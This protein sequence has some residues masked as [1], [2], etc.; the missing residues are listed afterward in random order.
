MSTVLETEPVAETPAPAMGH[1]ETL[2]ASVVILL[3]MTVAQRLIGFGRGILFCRWLDP[4]QLGQW[5]V[6]FGFL[7]LAASVAVLGLP[8][9]FGRYIGYFRQ[10]GQF[11]SFLWRTSAVS[12]LVSIVT[13]TIMIIQRDK[14]SWL[15]FGTED[16]ST[17][18]VYLAI[19]VAIIILHNH[20][21][22]LFIAVRRYRIV[23][24]LQFFQ[25]LGF[26]IVSL[27]LMMIWP[28]VCASVIIGYTVATVL[29]GFGSVRCMR[30]LAAEEPSTGQAMPQA[31]FWAKLM[32]FAIWMWFT[33]FVANLFDLV[34][35]YMIVHH[36]GMEA[37]EA[38]RQIGFYSSSR[39]VPLL[40][41]AIAGLL[42]S[43]IT[44]HLSHDW[45][46]GRRRAVGR[47]LNT[48]L[49]LLALVTYCGS[50]VMLFVA[51]ILF[52]VV[53]QNKLEGGLVVLPWTLTYCTWFG[54]IG[55]AQNYL[56]CAERP[57]LSSLPL[58]VGL[59]LNI[60]LNLLWLPTYGLEGAV[61]AT[62]LANLVAL[63]LVYVFSA[64]CGM[65]ID[66][67]TWILT[68][69]PA[70]LSLGPWVS[71]CMLAALGLATVTGNR[72]FTIQEKQQA[73][74]AVTHGWQKLRRHVGKL[75]EAAAD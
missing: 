31:V 30:D 55:V 11:A 63:V 36:S 35:R 60:G 39:I 13:A 43:M 62:T 67:G 25:S 17:T 46:M 45:E 15:V 29:S 70:S 53:F 5:D 50:T 71:L 42:G 33:G 28:A 26:A 18:I 3:V 56:W 4:E 27:G 68:L 38:L 32:P 22:A 75:P 48:V 64:R 74:E 73:V 24:T 54:M 66:L 65:K 61:W 58:L 20:L 19:C 72:V 8:G 37:N 40:F 69:V 57:A 16:Q 6:A 41:V 34:D 47:R 12:V 52:H 1:G 21:T 51:P 9:S 2:A 7:N 23:T 59:L 49:K 14:F 10:R 44:P